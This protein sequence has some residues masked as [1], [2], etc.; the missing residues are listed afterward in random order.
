M[1][2]L[3]VERKFRCLAVKRL[4]R[5]GGFPPFRSFKYC[6]K[7]TFHDVYYD[8]ADLLSS[9]GVW[10]RQRDG[11]WQA[12]IQRGGDYHNSKFEELSNPMD[13]SQYLAE[14]TGIRHNERNN[15][16][17][18]Q[19]AAFSTLR[20]SWVA[21]QDF[22]VVQDVTD[23]GHT[24]GEVELECRVEGEGSPGL[25]TERYRAAK[26]AEMDERITTFMKRYSW[27]FCAGVPKGKLTAY[28]ETFQ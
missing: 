3:E 9:K 14:L 19:M 26:M 20:E 23:F 10:I 12:K 2:V 15:F 18:M 13:I 21:D 8:K 22:T 27:A 5:D 17:L 6:G 28:F 7:Q 4:V 24:V 25:A 11:H 16:G 1:L